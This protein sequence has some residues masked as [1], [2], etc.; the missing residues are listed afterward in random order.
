MGSSILLSRTSPFIDF[1]VSSVLFHFYSISNRNSCK[2]TKDP[3]QT[4]HS[5]ASDLGLH[6]LPMSLLWDARHNWINHTNTKL[7]QQRIEPWHDKTNEVTV[8]P[9][10]TQDQPGHPHSL[11]SLRCPHEE[12]LG[13]YLR[14]QQRL[15]SDWAD[16]QADLSLRLAHSHFVGFVMSRLNLVSKVLKA[17]QTCMQKCSVDSLSQLRQ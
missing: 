17:I 9:A 12:S 8:Y 14:A 15:W 6:S 13:P 2:Q 10:K 3:D 7:R 11:I 1:G 4:L 16:A 5:V